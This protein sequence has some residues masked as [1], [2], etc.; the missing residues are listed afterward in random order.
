MSALKRLAF[1]VGF[2]LGMATFVVVAGNVLLYLLTG[3][4]PSVEISGDGT[5][6]FGLKSPQEVVSLVK[7]QVEKERAA[8]PRAASEA[9]APQQEE[10]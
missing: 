4:L 10:D 5:P 8:L 1:G 2:V 3:K 7:E 6:V 9:G